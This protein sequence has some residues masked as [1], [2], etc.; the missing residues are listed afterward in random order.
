VQRSS[1]ALLCLTLSGVMV[2][3][4][5]LTDLGDQGLYSSAWA[6]DGGERGGGNYGGSNN[7]NGKGKSGGSGN[8]SSGKSRSNVTGSAK[9]K[10]SAVAVVNVSIAAANAAVAMAQQALV[11]AIRAFETALAEP[12]TDTNTLLTL[13]RAITDAEK[14]LRKAS[15]KA[16]TLNRLE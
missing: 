16:A 10:S 3:T 4:S 11:E 6:K 14:S 1:S 8:S 5:G 15:T 9:P 7:G 12:R 2:M 13:E